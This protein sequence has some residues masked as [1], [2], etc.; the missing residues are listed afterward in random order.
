MKTELNN[1]E[2]FD[3]FAM[4]KSNDE[5][6]NIFGAKEPTVK[7]W[8]AQNGKVPEYAIKIINLIEQRDIYKRQIDNKN[9]EL[10]ANK[11]IIYDFVNSMDK[12]R[13][14]VTE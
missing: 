9:M 3:L 10:I 11:Q 2:V 7:G 13:S 14:I 6:S 5:L 8:K 4:D 1:K 12:L